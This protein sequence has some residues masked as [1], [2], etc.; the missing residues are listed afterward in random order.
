VANKMDP[1]DATDATGKKLHQQYTN[2]E[3]YLNSLVAS[4]DGK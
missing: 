4:K 3:V 2:I 1:N